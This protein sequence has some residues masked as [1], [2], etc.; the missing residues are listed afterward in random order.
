MAFVE[1]DP[2]TNKPIAAS[3]PAQN[4]QPPSGAG[5][6]GAG[7]SGPG[8]DLEKFAADS[9]NRQMLWAT[10]HG[11]RPTMG[12]FEDAR[13]AAYQQGFETVRQQQLEQE[14]AKIDIA[15]QTQ[16]ESQKS[17]LP[18]EMTSEEREKGSG[19][20]NAHAQI[21]Q[22]YNQNND[23]P[24]DHPYRAVQPV[25]DVFKQLGE[26]VD[27][28]VRLYEATRGGS[29]ISLG[30][31]LLQDT[32]QVAGKEQAQDLIKGLM[33][34]P[35]DS[36]QMSARKTADMLE[37]TMNGI[38]ARI[39]SMDPNIDTTTLK[40]EYARNYN[41]YAKIVNQFG[42]NAQRNNPAASPTDLFGKD[43][44]TKYAVTA[45]VVGG[46]ASPGAKAELVNQASG[47][48][49]SGTQMP[50]GLPGGHP[51]QTWTGFPSGV[52]SQFT[53]YPGPIG[54]AAQQAGQFQGGGRVQ[55]PGMAQ[56]D[57]A[58]IAQ[59]LQAPQQQKMLIPYLQQVLPGAGSAESQAESKVT[60][61]VG[62]FLRK[63]LLGQGQSPTPGFLPENWPQGAI[64]Q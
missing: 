50:S 3:Q 33:P 16:L 7:A 23:I 31:G 56:P 22:L 36:Q 5:A 19:L 42:S 2:A 61:P 25:G 11:F 27:D 60:G 12:D 37:L 17:F 49:P 64:Q 47:N 28:R 57:P 51:Q 35:G 40:Q 38:Q 55:T 59:L 1:L 18:R 34:G 52:P 13:K 21:M 24:A 32:G 20:M 54:A 29:I 53:S 6:S 62:D 48:Q 43:F 41:D 30:R 46:G 14:R 58:L 15:K 8:F 9:A 45:P 10:S 4:Q 63:M 26:K 44:G 39:N